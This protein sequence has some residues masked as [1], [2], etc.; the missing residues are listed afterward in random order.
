MKVG[1]RVRCN[2]GGPYNGKTGRVARIEPNPSGD[3]VYVV[4]DD[5][6]FND[7]EGTLTWLSQQLVI[8]EPTTPFAAS[9]QEWI[10]EAKRELGI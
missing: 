3:Y 4:M 10:D 8:V 7:W 1:D 5:W 6:S 9:V 2:I